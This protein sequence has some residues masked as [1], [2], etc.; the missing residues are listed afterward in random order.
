VQERDAGTLTGV[1]PPDLRDEHAVVAVYFKAAAVIIV[2]V[3]LGQVL[4]LRARERTSGAIRALLDL[5][6]KTATRVSADG[7]DEGA[8]CVR[9]NFTLNTMIRM[10]PPWY[11]CVSLY[12][13]AD[14]GRGCSAVKECASK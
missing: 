1:F 13:A 11:L 12:C 6:P 2:L 5:A 4:E 8:F 3:L 9:Q 10:R 7:E 14:C